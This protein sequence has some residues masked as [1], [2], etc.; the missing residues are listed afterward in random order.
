MHFQLTEMIGFVAGVACV[1]LG[2]Y[3]NVWNW[4]VGITSNVALFLLFRRNQVYAASGLQLVYIL[5]AVYGWRNW[6]RGGSKGGKLRITR[7]KSA[8]RILLLC[9][10]VI[11]AVGLHGI[12]QR[13]TNTTVAWPD[14]LG[15]SLLLAAQYCLSR[16]LLECW[17][18][19]IVAD[20]IYVALYLFK[21]LYLTPALYL[22]FLVMCV[23]GLARWRREAQESSFESAISTAD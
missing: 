6:L 20:L 14:A 3:E 4:P 2:M 13:F 21:G 5:I 1:L 22:F 17:L 16:K 23:I 12:L 15:T 11:A 7:A 9:A 18:F 10:T 19:W 8:E